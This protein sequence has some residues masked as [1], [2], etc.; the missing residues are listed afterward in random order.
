M[1]YERISGAQLF[2][3]MNTIKTHQ[4]TIYR[5]LGANSRR[6]AIDIARAAKLI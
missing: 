3:S 2:V 6:Q 1:P 4:K 5:K